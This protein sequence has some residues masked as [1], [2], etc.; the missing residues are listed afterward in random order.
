[1]RT[2]ISLSL[3]LLLLASSAV[4]QVKNKDYERQKINEQKLKT[5]LAQQSDAVKARYTYRHPFETL[6]FFG[7][8]P[9]MTVVEVLPYSGWYSKILAAYLGKEGHIIAADYPL[10]L[11]QHFS[12]ADADYVQQRKQD[13]L[14]FANRIT[15][16]QPLNTPKASAYTFDTM[17]ASLSNSVD[18]VLFIRALHNLARFNA[19]FHY[20]DQALSE[21][22][23][24]LKPGGI[25]GIVQ[26]ETSQANADGGN[27]YLNRKQVIQAMEKA[28]FTL[29]AESNVNS[30]PKDQPSANE[31]VWRLPPSLDV[32]D[33][34]LRQRYLAIGE[35]N[36]MT[37]LFKK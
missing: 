35:S 20:L 26:H 31:E 10:P 21:S 30:N 18:A 36:R 16:W 14:E 8:K 32:K 1:M 7:I 22:Y 19:E 9:G 23:R 33:E 12:W 15:Q 6:V 37:L 11:W 29:Q 17:P 13:T 27:G 34:A 25:V 24:I 28:G 2:F 3:S 4:S 5:V